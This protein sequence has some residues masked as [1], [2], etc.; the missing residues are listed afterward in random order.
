MTKIPTL[1]VFLLFA[2]PSCAIKRD[3][4]NVA[5]SIS[6]LVTAAEE[7]VGEAKAA[8]VAAKAT[9]ASA[10]GEA[11]TDGDGKTS[12]AEWLTWVSLALGGSGGAAALARGAIR[13][14]KSDGRKDLMEGR[15]DALEKPTG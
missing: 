8:L 15:I 4:E 3:L 12:M 6:V 10:K 9:Y 1:L 7:T 11:D 5:A 2:L 14:A 13:N